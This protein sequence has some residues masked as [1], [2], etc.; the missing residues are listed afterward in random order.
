[1]EDEL[2][3]SRYLGSGAFE[4]KKLQSLEFI[5]AV[6]ESRIIFACWGC[7][8]LSVPSCIT[9]CVAAPCTSYGGCDVPVG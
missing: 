2:E 3:I 1:M 4:F 6:F 7:E 8:S 9:L 5:A